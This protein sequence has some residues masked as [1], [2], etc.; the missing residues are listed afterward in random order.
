M[1]PRVSAFLAD[2]VRSISQ[3]ACIALGVPT[4][5]VCQSWKVDPAHGSC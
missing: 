5:A 2:I 3:T 1:D 4:S